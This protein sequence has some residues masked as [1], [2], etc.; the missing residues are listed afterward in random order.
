V[1]GWAAILV[2]ALTAIAVIQEPSAIGLIGVALAVLG[3]AAVLGIQIG[4]ARHFRVPLGFALLFPLAYSAVAALAWH[5]V[6]RR[7][8]GH[9]SWKG[10]T[11]ALPRKASPGRP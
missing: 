4:T 11:Y 9:I 8:A 7:R 1:V 6:A 10:R 3:S 5:S 2:P